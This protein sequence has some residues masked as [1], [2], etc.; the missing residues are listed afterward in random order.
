VCK[1]DNINFPSSFIKVLKLFKK[2][3]MSIGLEKSQQSTDEWG[4]EGFRDYLR[5]I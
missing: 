4:V 1:K 2:S 3:V 5:I